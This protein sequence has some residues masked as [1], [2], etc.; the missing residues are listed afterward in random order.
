MKDGS[1]TQSLWDNGQTKEWITA[2]TPSPVFLEIPF[3]SSER[4]RRFEL[5]LIEHLEKHH[6]VIHMLGGLPPSETSVLYPDI[7]PEAILE[8][9]TV[10]AL[11][12]ISVEEPLPFLVDVLPLFKN[13]KTYQDWLGLMRDACARIPKMSIIV[14]LSIL[15][16]PFDERS[17]RLS[18]DI[19]GISKDLWEGPSPRFCQVM[20]SV[21]KAD[22]VCA[23]FDKQLDDIDDAKMR[24]PGDS[25]AYTFGLIGRHLVVLIHMPGMGK[26]NGAIVAAKSQ[27]SFPNIKL[28]LVVGICG[29][30]PF[31]DKGKREIILGDIIV[32]QGLIA[33]D[34]GRRFPNE[35]VSKSSPD[36][37]FARPP[38]EIR[39][40]LGK[41]KSQS[42]LR[43]L[44]ER[45]CQYLQALKL[46]SD[47]RAEY[48]GAGEDQLF[49]GKYV[50][51]HR[52][53]ETCDICAGSTGVAGD[54]CEEARGS[55]C[56]DV[57]CDKGMLVP[58]QRLEAILQ[59]T[60]APVPMIHF[61]LIACGDQVMKSGVHRDKVAKDK[62]VIAFEMEGAGVWDIFPCVVLKA[63]CDYADSHKHKKWQ[64][65][66][67]AT[68]AACAKAFLKEWHM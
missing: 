66:A 64:S 52:A 30:V 9:L 23:L 27:S 10:Q 57:S 61:G 49:N 11:I 22:A 31:Y 29:G 13:A 67:A 26:I 65:Y 3:S 35:F 58:R 28:A 34:Y 59:G 50:H 39:S 44:Q 17:K 56:D 32:S 47:C 4:V 18:A 62:D 6:P 24:A 33:Y 2:D 42:G 45:T 14:D 16:P 1:T 54:V 37:V 20:L 55:S 19:S 8:H 68:A 41:L 15:L 60:E 21:P 38:V 25:N 7:T 51:K 36:D 12:H 40:L 5:E 53:P 46:H 63:V 48:P 43:R